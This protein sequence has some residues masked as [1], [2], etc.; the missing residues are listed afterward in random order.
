MTRSRLYGGED[1]ADVPAY[2]LAEAAQLVGVPASTL[3]KW[4]KGRSYLT[5]QG[6]TRTSAPVI[7]T[8]VKGFLSFT[9]IVEAHVL[10]GLRKERVGL[11]NIRSAVSCVEKK[12]G[13]LHPLARE[14]FKTDG[15]S[16]FV[17]KLGKLLNVSQDGQVAIREVLDRHLKRVEFVGGRAVRL[18]PL[19]R[20]GAPQAIVIDPR[21]AFGRPTLVGTSVP[22]VDI[23]S[24]FEHGDDVAVLALDYQVPP[25]AVQEALRASCKAA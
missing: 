23:V 4:T 19:H 14:D 5:R 22:I 20:P 8:K 1:P 9:N 15:V 18:F 25:E 13:V 10:A 7:R 16:L 3:Q 12:F 24:R 6:G 11:E 2:T 17:E 21:R